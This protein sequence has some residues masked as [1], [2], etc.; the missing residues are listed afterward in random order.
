MRGSAAVKSEP[1]FSI[2]GDFLLTHT[3]YKPKTMIMISWGK[4]LPDEIKDKFE[5]LKEK[6]KK[7][8]FSISKDMYDL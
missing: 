6:E 1:W 3:R 4:D 2:D 8:G 7:L 5:A